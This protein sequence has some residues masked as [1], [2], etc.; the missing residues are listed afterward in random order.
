MSNERKTFSSPTDT[1]CIDIM[2][3]SLPSR[4]WSL[5]KHCN[6]S[7]SSSN[8]DTI[9]AA[10]RVFFIFQSL[11]FQISLSNTCLT[12]ESLFEVE[13]ELFGGRSTESAVNLV[14]KR[15]PRPH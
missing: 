13:I 9:Q 11:D 12:R 14:V 15:T 2:S 3:H 1:V 7:Q 4:K 5:H 6:L 10:G 8:G